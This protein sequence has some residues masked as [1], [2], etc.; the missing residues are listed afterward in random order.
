MGDADDKITA[1]EN[2]KRR[3]MDE[4]TGILTGRSMR[5]SAPERIAL[6]IKERGAAM[7]ELD[8]QIAAL[9]AHNVSAAGA[10]SSE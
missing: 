2:D 9:E 4:V 10:A 6:A 8:I 1:L 5:G 3:L 7:Q